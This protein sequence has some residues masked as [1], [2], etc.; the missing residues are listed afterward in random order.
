[1]SGKSPEVT[2]PACGDPAQ[3]RTPIRYWTGHCP[4]F[5]CK[6]C[7]AVDVL[8]PDGKLRITPNLPWR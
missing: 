1:M 8:K 5:Y 3:E 2:C 6:K 4:S 7:G